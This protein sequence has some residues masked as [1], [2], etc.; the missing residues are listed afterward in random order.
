MK[1]KTIL[2][3]SLAS[4]ITC[5]VSHA[6]TWNNGTA[7]STWDTATSANWTGSTWTAGDAAVFGATGVGGVTIATGGVSASSVTFNT[8]GYTIGG[9]P[10]TLTGAADITTTADAL[11]S[12]ALTGSAGLSKN[13]AGTLTLSGTST[14]SGSTHLTGGLLDV[15][16]QIYNGGGGAEVVTIG[17]GGTLRVYGLNT[18]GHAESLGGLG[19]ST[20][21]LVLD[22][23]T[24]EYAGADQ[25]WGYR[26][27]TVGT[28]GATLKASQSAG[29]WWMLDNVTNN[30]SLTLDG[31][32][33]GDIL[34]VISGSGALIKN[35]SGSWT[36]DN[37]NSYTG[38]TIVNGGTL[39]L[40]DPSATF[41][42][43][44]AVTLA[45]ASGATL[46]SSWWNGPAQAQVGISF[47]IG[48]L[49]GGGNLGGNVDLWPCTMTIGTDNTS[50]TFGGAINN[51]GAPASITKVGTGT[52]TLA[53]TN[54]YF[55]N[56]TV[57]GGV[58]DVTGQIYNGGGGSSVVTVGSGG[59]LKFYGL[60]TSGHVDSLGGLGGGNANLV[61]DGGT[62]EYAG[63]AQSY[64]ARP[65]SVGAGGA[66]LKASQAS[67][68]WYLVN[69]VTNNSS[70]TLEGAAYGDIQGVISGTG[71]LIKNGS[72]TWVLE[73]ANSY[74]GA[75]TVNDGTL[76]LN[77]PTANLGT[78]S[79]LTLANAADVFLYNGYWN[80]DINKEVGSDFSIGSLAGGGNLGGTVSLWPCTM[81]IGT[82]NTSTT[83][84]GVIYNY[85]APASITK[86]G[87]GTLT[88]TGAN[89]YAGN[90]TI[91][92]GTLSIAQPALS[93]TMT[94]TIGSTVG[95]TAVLNLPNAGTDKVGALVLRGV[96][97]PDGFYQA[98]NTGGAITGLGVIQVGN[99]VIVLTSYEK[100][101]ASYTYLTDTNPTHDPDGDGMTNQQ[102]Y[103]FG[104][105][106]TS[107]ASNNPIVVPFNKTAGTFS[108]TRLD[109][110]NASTGATGLT[111]RI[112]TST[113]LSTWTLD[114]GADQN[115]ITTDA[116]V[117][118]VDVTLSGLPLTA[119]KLFVRVA[120]E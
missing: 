78:N 31:A 1:S 28:G 75:T 15:T 88:L 74:T 48:S 112:Y 4:F 33:V 55:G 39:R 36:L 58:L 10:L 106:P 40:N 9:D 30:S 93:D 25:T 47:S 5:A 98:S 17:S 110:I 24:L 97:Q 2:A 20:A 100:W 64:A 71:S 66:T 114:A 115:V 107:G 111:Y 44:S 8:A 77:G 91:E 43:N 82:D 117:Q 79:A 29:H 60:G 83:F 113:N 84:G 51:Y 89:T 53:G 7:N 102:E 18:S 81:T 101:A 46:M 19:G 3:A 13:G 76:R 26:P 120:A 50:T 103:A 21:N 95:S 52:L 59:T 38:A 35:G 65:F 109:P 105:D 27:F 70:L 72:G 11:V 34:G 14:Y 32:A 87:T 67:Q 118:T 49:S 68:W 119:P 92:A 45:N 63:A 16:G 86:V 12:A 69:G 6:L 22:G 90:T 23:G 94:L 99:P 96:T 42:S 104:L 37:A 116:D 62:F 54:T 57:N 108:Y 80:S 73:Y 41:G 61:I 56:T 85:G